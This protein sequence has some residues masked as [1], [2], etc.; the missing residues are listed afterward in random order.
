VNAAAAGPGGLLRVD[1]EVRAYGVNGGGTLT[2]EA[3]QAIGLGLA[4]VGSDGTLP[5]G[6]ASSAGL[7]LA[8]DYLVEAGSAIPFGFSATVTRVAPG[9]KI[10]GPLVPIIS[11]Q[12]PL[13]LA[14]DW[15]VPPGVASAQF[16]TAPFF[17]GPGTRVPKGA[18]MTALNLAGSATVTVAADAFPD[19]IPV[20][21]VTTVYAAG[22]IVAQ[23]LVIAAGTLL[24]PGTTLP[25]DVA[26]KPVLTLRGALFESGFA[27]YEIH[28]HDGVTLPAGATLEVAMPVYRWDGSRQAPATGTDPAQAL[29]RWTPPLYEEHPDSARLA[30]RLGA[31]L[32][33]LAGSAYDASSPIVLGEG[34]TLSVDPG[35]SVSLLS[36]GGQVTLEGRVNAWGG[37][38]AVNTRY[39]FFHGA[40]SSFVDGRSIWVGEHAVL[41][42]AAR[43]YVAHD[44]EGR[45][46]GVAPDGGSIT[47]GPTDDFVVIRPGA[48]LDASG[49]QATVDLAAGSGPLNEEPPAEA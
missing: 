26:V 46:Y 31:D 27:H 1:G 35:Q 29:Q 34:S 30:Q 42:A 12:K 47:L 33:L 44:S 22:A 3:A 7:R 19:G 32:V 6:Q 4:P 11:A 5:A 43:A 21:P 23:P 37:A 48:L 2:I 9:Q 16:S 40:A 14:A 41:D 39:P 17:A 18:V 20:K 28:G 13:T 36:S 24:Q 10:G 25:V 45:A 38:I 15:V 8:N 49:A